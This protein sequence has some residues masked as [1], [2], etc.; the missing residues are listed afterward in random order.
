MSARHPAL[1]IL[2]KRARAAH[3]PFGDT[4]WAEYE[5]LKRKLAEPGSEQYDGALREILDALECGE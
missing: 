3:R 2:L 1:S 4:D 5:F